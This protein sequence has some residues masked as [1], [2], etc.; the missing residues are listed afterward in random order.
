MHWFCSDALDPRAVG[1]NEDVGVLGTTEHD[2]V[3]N[4]GLKD[5]GCLGKHLRSRFVDAAVVHHDVHRPGQHVAGTRGWH[6][7]DSAI[8]FTCS[9]HGQ[10]GL[11]CPASDGE[12]PD[13]EHLHLPMR[14]ERS[15]FVGLIKGLRVDTRHGEPP[16]FVNTTGILVGWGGANGWLAPN[17][18]V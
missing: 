8:G 9:D 13:L 5:R 6:E 2:V 11:E 10:P 17:I 18:R 3:R 1:P 14:D 16:L 7:S 15:N 12:A 4:L